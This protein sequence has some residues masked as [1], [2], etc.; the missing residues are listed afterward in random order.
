[1]GRTLLAESAVFAETIAACEVALGP[2]VDWSLTA[3]LCG[4]EA[5]LLERVDVIQPALFAMNIGLAA[6]W[7]SFGLEPS[8]V[9]GHSQGEIAA[10]VVAGILSLEDGARVVALRSQLLR[11]LSGRGAMAV[12][13]LAAEAVQERLKAAE[14][15]GLSLAVV[16]TPTSTVGSGASEAV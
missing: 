1:M 7:R 11:R 6:V 14:W 9:V 10:A 3:A 12:T 2:Y 5:S 15:A 16:N 13:E 4:D 8:A